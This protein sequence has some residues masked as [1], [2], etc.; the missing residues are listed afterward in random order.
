MNHPVRYDRAMGRTVLS[1]LALLGVVG[2]AQMKANWEAQQAAQARAEADAQPANLE[3]LCKTV[4]QSYCT[5][6]NINQNDC[7][8]MYVDCIGANSPA[9]IS[10]LTMGQ[11]SQCATDTNVGDCAVMPRVWPASCSATPQQE[12][13]VEQAQQ[14]AQTVA[15]APTCPQGA[16]WDGSQCVCPQGAQWDGSQCVC[17]E[18]AQW[19]GSQCVCPQGTAWDG[20]ACSVAVTAPKPMPRVPDCRALVIAKYGPSELS[21]C[22]GAEPFCA[23]AVLQKGYAPIELANCRG[24][25]G[26]CAVAVIQKGYAP[27]ELTNCRNVDSK[28]ALEVLNKGYAPVELANCKR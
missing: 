8:Q 13:A 16:Q 9:A 28:C 23:E 7:A 20:Q 24:V 17:P 25:K 14:P 10:A 26:R 22:I 4:Q 3:Q 18:G 21:Q 5:H 15:S 19:D 11:L 6:C 1:S 12:Q 2:C 27:V